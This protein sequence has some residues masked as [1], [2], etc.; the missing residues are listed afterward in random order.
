M[1][2]KVSTAKDT[3]W[4]VAPSTDNDYVDCGNDD[5]DRI[6]MKCQC[7]SGVLK[8]TTRGRQAAGEQRQRQTL[9]PSGRQLLIDSNCVNGG[10]RK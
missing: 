6:S 9:H 5:F 3:E 7:W 1:F 4:C 2:V 10:Q 8:S